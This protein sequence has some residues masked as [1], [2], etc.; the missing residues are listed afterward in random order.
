[1]GF[2]FFEIHGLHGAVHALDH[3]RHAA[4]DLPHRDGGLHPARDGV[5]AR[6]QAQEVELL[7]LLADGVL[8]VDLG[9]VWMVLL[10]GL[11]L[12]GALVRLG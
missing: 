2:Y 6:A 12:G 3:A 1:M 10:D 5:D 8:G 11:V 4:C 9:D 7:V